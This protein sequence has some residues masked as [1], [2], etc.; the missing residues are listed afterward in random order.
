MTK[1]EKHSSPSSAPRANAESLAAF[2]EALALMSGHDQA[3]SGG[4]NLPALPLPSLLERCEDMLARRDQHASRMRLLLGFPGLDP[5]SPSWWRNRLVGIGCVRASVS[6]SALGGL[7]PDASSEVGQRAMTAMLN[8]LSSELAQEGC[9]L[10]V[11]AEAG[12]LL[13]EGPWAHSLLLVCHPATSY[14]AMLR[15]S[16]PSPPTLDQF[17]DD[18]LAVLATQPDLSWQRIE[19]LGDSHAAVLSA[20]CRRLEIRQPAGLD[21]IDIPGTAPAA[22]APMGGADGYQRLCAQLGYDPVDIPPLP[23]A[24]P[25]A[26]NRRPGHPNGSNR[27]P[28]LVSQFLQRLDRVRALAPNGGRDQAL[29]LQSGVDVIALL[30]AC[31]SEGEENLLDRLDATLD[32]LLPA[33][34]ALLLFACA[35]HFKVRGQ[36]L[37]ALS[38]VAEGLTQAAATAQGRWLQVLGAALYA[39]LG[40]ADQALTTLLSDVLDS[41]I[42][43][44][45]DRDKLTAQLEGLTQQQAREHGHALLIEHLTRTPPPQDGRKRLMVEIG[46]TR[47]QIAGQGSTLKLAQLCTNLGLDFV[48]VDMDPRNTHQAQMMFRRNGFAFSAVTAKGED[49]LAGFDGEIDYVFLD[50]YDFD[51]GKH[52]DLRQSRYEEFLGSRIEETK[53]HQMHL[54]C[55]TALVDKLAPDGLI[56]FDDTWQDESGAWTA[57]GA[58]AMPF[59]LDNGFEIIAARNNAAL[60]RRVSRRNEPCP[61]LGDTA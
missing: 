51:H 52:S 27:Q 14:R 16:P 19:D 33:D 5:V 46:T 53:C 17:C 59:L 25:T 50:A 55:A 61:I 47:E 11:T 21:D 58:T 60:L 54:D 37:Q 2:E 32:T 22:A 44:A 18:L 1:S 23:A 49:Y 31:L 20:L 43:T 3:P 6:A 57:K 4:A 28:A 42:L 45:P 39:D 40:A 8:T 35:S 13:P 38:F 34:A 29:M 48:T 30:D 36:R 56:C 15:R 12:D 24:P 9:D 26:A 10:L 41:G 7:A